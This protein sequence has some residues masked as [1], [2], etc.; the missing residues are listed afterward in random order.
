M[1]TLALL[2]TVLGLVSGREMY[3]GICTEFNITYGVNG[4]ASY[5]EE[6]HP[7]KA[8]YQKALN[9]CNR[10]ETFL[11]STLQLFVWTA[12]V[13]PAAMAAYILFQIFK[14]VSG[15][16]R[17]GYRA[18]GG[19]E[20]WIALFTMSSLVPVWNLI[21]LMPVFARDIKVGTAIF[22]V[23]LTV[24]VQVLSTMFVMRAFGFNPCRRRGAAS[25]GMGRSGKQMREQEAKRIAELTRD[26]DGIFDDGYSS[27]RVDEYNMRAAVPIVS[28]PI[29]TK[30]E[31]FSNC[32]IFLEEGRSMVSEVIDHRGDIGDALETTDGAFL[33]FHDL[34]TVRSR[35]LAWTSRVPAVPSMSRTHKE[36]LAR[37]FMCARHSDVTDLGYYLRSGSYKIR[38]VVTN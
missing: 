1:K 2:I 4:T 18:L 36:V 8:M 14:P 23:L 22:M 28:I 27:D 17:S 33:L 24:V 21:V 32:I 26:L 10:M 7:Y 29:D 16:G 3:E 11:C 25:T 5:G 34:I 37:P 12:F 31:D 9:T 19:P 35:L 6:L 38:K 15:Y 13:L 20:V 30:I